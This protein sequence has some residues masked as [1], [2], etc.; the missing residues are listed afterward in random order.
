MAFNFYFLSFFCF[1]RLR[2]M[3]KEE[4]GSNFGRD[5]IV[6]VLEDFQARAEVAL[7]FVGVKH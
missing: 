4:S 6:E 2:K 7:C 3:L 5:K 1:C